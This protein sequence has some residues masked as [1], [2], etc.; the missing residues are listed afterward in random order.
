MSLVKIG[1]KLQGAGIPT[2][3]SIIVI[4]PV[5][6]ICFIC[7]IRRI[8]SVCFMPRGSCCIRELDIWIYQWTQ[9][10]RVNHVLILE[11]RWQSFYYTKYTLQYQSINEPPI[12]L[13]SYSPPYPNLG[14]RLLSKKLR[15]NSSWPVP[16]IFAS[17][18]V[19]LTLVV[20]CM[21]IEPPMERTS[22]V[23]TMISTESLFTLTTLISA[24]CK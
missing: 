15:N 18:I 2:D 24:S 1:R 10:A 12:F 16:A 3:P 9:N 7:C 14:T 22:L 17:E 5:H 20:L 21:R 8:I 4:I 23:S 11:I 13:M 6:G 19:T